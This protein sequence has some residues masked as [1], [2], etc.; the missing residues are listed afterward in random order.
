MLSSGSF[1]ESLI[2]PFK[3]LS[4]AAQGSMDVQ[5]RNVSGGRPGK[6]LGRSWQDL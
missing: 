2:Y 1:L 5:G 3:D 4:E 6:E